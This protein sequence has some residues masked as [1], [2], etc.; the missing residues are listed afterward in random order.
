MTTSDWWCS[1]VEVADRLVDLFEGPVE[2][3]PCSNPR[4]VIKA[5]Q[6]YTEGGLIKPWCLTGRQPKKRTAYE[7]P[8]Y[9]MGDEFTAKA[10][11]ELRLGNVVELVRLTMMST[12][13]Q[14]WADQC[15]KP[16]RNPRILA[17]KRLKF[18]DPF[19]KGP[20]QE[21]QSCRFEPALTYFGP[22]VRKFD[23]AFADLT[24]WSTWGR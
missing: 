20:G 11:A 16:K 1:P 18:I 19:A 21:R 2:V 4:S 3:D 22:N 15:T 13:T 9:S 8:P 7:N 17:L 24:R 23:R 12:S 10:L 14:W 5:I 6:V